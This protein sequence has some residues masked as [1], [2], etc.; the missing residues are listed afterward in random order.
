MCRHRVSAD[1]VRVLGDEAVQCPSLEQQLLAAILIGI[2]GA[3][4]DGDLRMLN[5]VAF[6]VAAES[7]EAVDRKT[8]TNMVE[9]MK[10]A[11]PKIDAMVEREMEKRDRERAAMDEWLRQAEEGLRS[12]MGE[13]RLGRFH[14]LDMALVSLLMGGP[15]FQP[16]GYIVRGVDMA[17]P[18]GEYTASQEDPRIKPEAEEMEQEEAWWLQERMAEYDAHSD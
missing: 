18:D 10:A 11:Q 2:S 12:R 14:P 1:R 16:G 3:L 13:A 6:L 7:A 17:A 4:R 5:K 9:E 8:G 15:L